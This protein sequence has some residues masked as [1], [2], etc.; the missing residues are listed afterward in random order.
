M[1]CCE[2][3]IGDYHEVCLRH[4]LCLQHVKQPRE[5]V[6]HSVCAA[7]E[8]YSC[9][10]GRTLSPIHGLQAAVRE[11]CPPK[12]AHVALPSMTTT[13]HFYI[14]LA[15]RPH[16]NQTAASS[17]N[18]TQHAIWIHHTTVLQRQLPTLSQ[19]RTDVT[20]LSDIVGD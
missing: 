10:K 18:D 8:S 20:E 4:T 1:Q 9:G 5:R 11:R 15:R 7:L 2:E 3:L 13:Y 16:Q 17:I 6:A 12:S 14:W 19:P